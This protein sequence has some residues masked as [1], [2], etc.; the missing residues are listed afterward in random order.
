MLTSII[1][2][3]SLS[4]SPYCHIVDS[5]LHYHDMIGIH[6][7]VCRQLNVL[8]TLPINYWVMESHYSLERYGELIVHFRSF[9]DSFPRDFFMLPTLKSSGSCI[10][11]AEQ[12]SFYVHPEEKRSSLLSLFPLADLISSWSPLKSLNI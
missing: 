4:I 6:F 9:S 2:H 8:I 5:N 10:F 3:I 7:H 1:Q 12:I 11:C